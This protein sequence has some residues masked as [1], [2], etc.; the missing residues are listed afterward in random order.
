MDKKEFLNSLNEV[1]CRLG[2]TKNGVGVVAIRDIPKGTNPFKNCN[3]DS[4]KI[5]IP[6]TELDAHSAPE[7]VKQLIRDFCPLE[8][9]AYFVPQFGIDAIDKSYFLNHSKTPN[10]ET[11]DQGDTFIAARD[12]SQ[13]EELTSDY[14]TYH[15]RTNDTFN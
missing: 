4:A 5:E 12:I 13:G 3:N 11:P 9:G 15:D 8:N 6:Q 10:L 2:V 7:S 14:N 1:Y